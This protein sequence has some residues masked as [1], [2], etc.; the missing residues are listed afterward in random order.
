MLLIL[1]ILN[2]FILAD[3]SLWL[4]GFYSALP[5]LCPVLFLLW[6]TERKIT[7][8]KLVI[9]MI[10]MAV[11]ASQISFLAVTSLL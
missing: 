5:V 4:V 2:L 3:K 8:N 9:V 6:N 11:K 1:V 7:Q 10:S